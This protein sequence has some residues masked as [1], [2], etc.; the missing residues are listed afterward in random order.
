MTSGN[1][2]LEQAMSVAK[3][4]LNSCVSLHESCAKVVIQGAIQPRRVLDVFPQQMDIIIIN[5]TLLEP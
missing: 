4:W 3:E 5:L 2:N 1:T